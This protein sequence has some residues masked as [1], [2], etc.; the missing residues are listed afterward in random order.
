MQSFRA[1]NK[2]VRRGTDEVERITCNESQDLAPAGV[3]DRNVVGTDHSRGDYAVA[4]LALERG[5]HNDVVLPDIPERPEKCVA[6]P[7]NTNVSCLSR[8]RRTGN[9][10][11]ARKDVAEIV[12]IHDT[13][14]RE[15]KKG[16][17][18]AVEQG[19]QEAVAWVAHAEGKNDEAAKALRAVAEKEEAEGDEPLAIPAREMLADMMLEMNRPEEALAEYEADLKFNPNRF[20]WSLRRGTGC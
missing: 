5:D 13:L 12:T 18:E 11:D 17:A 14:L 1:D 16:F 9:V 15:K 20:Q 7:G 10:A 8:Q 6:V 4:I 19:R 3:Q 2:P